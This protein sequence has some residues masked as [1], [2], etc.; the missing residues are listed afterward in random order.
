METMKT[1]HRLTAHDYPDTMPRLSPWPIQSPRQKKKR[2]SL[3]LS[4]FG[5]Y[6][7][8]PEGPACSSMSVTQHPAAHD[9]WAL[10][11]A[12]ATPVTGT[13]YRAQRAPACA[14]TPFDVAQVSGSLPGLCR[15]PRG[16]RADIKWPHAPPSSLPVALFFVSLINTS[17]L[18]LYSWLHSSRTAIV[19]PFFSFLFLC[20]H[21]TAVVVQVSQP[22]AS[23]YKC[24]VK[25]RPRAGGG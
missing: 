6:I 16:C 17:P 14:S 20:I 2:K 7:H 24:V 11:R 9:P 5:L 3:I 12:K 21:S 15:E 18:P 23:T 19:G 22:K 25:A 4:V 1:S 13:N 8:P 10:D